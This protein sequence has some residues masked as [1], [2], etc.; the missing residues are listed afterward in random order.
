[1]KRILNLVLAILICQMA[2]LLGILAIMPAIPTWYSGLNKPDFSPPNWLFAPVWTLLYALMG[3]SAFLI[4]QLGM[5]KKEV[6]T[7]LAVFTLQLVLNMLWSFLFFGLHLPLL[8][9][10]EILFLWLLILLTINK[11][12]SLSKPAAFLLLPYLLWVSFAA[13]LNFFIVRLN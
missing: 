2:G 4:W 5:D 1:M 13:L 10:G 3:A 11:F 9:F 6:K 12:W 7:A 8:A